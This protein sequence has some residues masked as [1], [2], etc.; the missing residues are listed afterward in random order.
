MKKVGISL[1]DDQAEAI[2]RIRRK[3]RIPRSRVVQEAIATYLEG[4]GESD[5]VRRYIE[6]YRRRPEGNEARAYAKAAAM[7]LGSEDWE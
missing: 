7:V 1:P 6:G 2:E 5:A 3:R 4:Q